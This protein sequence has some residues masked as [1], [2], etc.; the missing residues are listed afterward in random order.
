MRT[1]RLFSSLS[2]PP[3][4]GYDGSV[5]G[6]LV[7]TTRLKS[8]DLVINSGDERERD[9]PLY[10]FECTNSIMSVINDRLRN[11]D[12]YSQEKMYDNENVASRELFDTRY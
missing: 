12:N 5:L 8:I 7:L 4:R 9:C 3:S 6:L 11:R 2:G 10:H 1:A